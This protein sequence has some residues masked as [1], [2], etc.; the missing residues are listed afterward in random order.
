MFHRLRLAADHH[1]IA[2]LEAPDSAARA[3]VH[4]M[5]PAGRKFFGTADV[6]D[7]IG[8]AAVDE[9]VALFKIR[10]DL[11]DRLVHNGRRHHEPDRA[12][13]RQFVHE[14]LEA[15]RAPG[16]FGHQSL[17]GFRRPVEHNTIKP[18]A[19]QPPDHIRAHS[20]ESNHSELHSFTPLSY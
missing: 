6:V 4:V 17:N 19:N 13:R 12:R 11:G 20:S 1:A 8:I 14:V 16:V 10:Q 5:N 2:A 7:V 15:G 3:H 9:N 18:A